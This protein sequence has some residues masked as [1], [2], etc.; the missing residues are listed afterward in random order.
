MVAIALWACYGAAIGAGCVLLLKRM[1][2]GVLEGRSVMGA[3]A[4]GIQPLIHFA[5]L[6]VAALAGGRNGLL[7]AAAGD[8][9]L[10]VV[11]GFVLFFRGRR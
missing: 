7:S 8:V 5:A 11:L 3:A 1:L 9:A 4:I 6:L 10:S 2:A